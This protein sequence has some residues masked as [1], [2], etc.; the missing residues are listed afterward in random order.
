MR[1]FVNS[2]STYVAKPLV[3]Q[4]VAEGHEIVG[5]TND[6]TLLE[7]GME[8][9]VELVSSTNKDGVAELVASAEVTILSLHDGGFRD[10]SAILRSFNSDELSGQNAACTRTKQRTHFHK[11]CFSA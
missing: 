7:K 5:S 2:V 3:A 1:I 9:V 4:L 6:L 10:K 8:G 11:S